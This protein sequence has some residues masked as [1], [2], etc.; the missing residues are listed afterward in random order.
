MLVYFPMNIPEVTVVKLPNI[1][2]KFLYIKLFLNRIP[3]P[4]L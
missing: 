4:L 1:M 2:V 3:F